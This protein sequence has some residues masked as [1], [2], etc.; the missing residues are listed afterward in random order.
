MNSGWT[1][2]TFT[3]TRLAVTQDALGGQVRTYTAAARAGLPTEVCGRAIRLKD[4]EKL[5]HGVRGEKNGWKLLVPA[6][7]PN[8]LI[9]LTDKVEF[10]YTPGETVVMKVTKATHS[11]IGMTAD[12][13]FYST[14]GEEDT[15][16]V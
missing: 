4:T 7:Q 3:I 5:D 11:R 9:A 13:S 10:E 8:P 1:P 16:E 6:T 2:H 14:S 15:S 12:S